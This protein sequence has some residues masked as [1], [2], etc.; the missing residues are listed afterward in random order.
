ME[1]TFQTTPPETLLETISIEALSVL[2]LGGEKGIP[3]IVPLE[4][5][6][7]LIA[8]AWSLPET[9]LKENTDL[10]EQGK[11]QAA[12][13]EAVLPENTALEYYDG[14]TITS[15]LWGLFE[16]AARLDG[17][18]ERQAIYDA[19]EV[20]TEA[21]DYESFLRRSGKSAFRLLKGMFRNIVRRDDPEKRKAIREKAGARVD[22]LHR[23]GINLSS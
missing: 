10:L 23:S 3:D 9:L 5:A 20:L 18:E 22:Q 1:L 14:W 19:A 2:A 15:L 7:P 8:K 17:R 4:A 11:A 6:L 21:L 13:G 16:T 12:R